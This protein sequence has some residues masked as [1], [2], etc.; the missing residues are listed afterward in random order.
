MD[1]LVHVEN[2]AL[3][4]GLLV[5]IASFGLYIRRTRDIKAVVFFWQKRLQLTPQEF[6]INRIGLGLMIFGVAVRLIYHTFFIG[7]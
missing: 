6:I 7:G 5:V 1:W 4:S 3:L 2:F